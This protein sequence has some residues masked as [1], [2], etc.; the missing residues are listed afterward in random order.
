[1]SVLRGKEKRSSLGAASPVVARAPLTAE[2]FFSTPPQAFLDDVANCSEDVMMAHVAELE[3]VMRVAVPGNS[4]A[5]AEV[6]NS[7]TELAACSQ[8]ARACCAS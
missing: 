4:K 2:T 5:I 1:M 8:S 3:K 6:R 7:P